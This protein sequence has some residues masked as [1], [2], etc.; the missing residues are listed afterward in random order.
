MCVQDVACLHV[1]VAKW[2]EA[3][4]KK[5][6]SER[7]VRPPRDSPVLRSVVRP[8]AGVLAAPHCVIHRWEGLRPAGAFR[9]TPV[10]PSIFYT[11]YFYLLTC[12]LLQQTNEETLEKKVRSPM[13]S[14]LPRGQ[15]F[16][17]SRRKKHTIRA[18]RASNKLHVCPSDASKLP[19][20]FALPW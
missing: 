20:T 18:K 12:S 4:G 17:E 19:S 1:L 14:S 15:R 10:A 2:E 7:G 9:I 13:S 5:K 8:V 3:M 6:Y 16:L 11:W